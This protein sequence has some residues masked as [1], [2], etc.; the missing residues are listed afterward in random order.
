MVASASRSTTVSRTSSSSSIDFSANSFNSAE[1]R[2]TRKR[3]TA[4][5][6]AHLED[7]YRR[8]SHPTRDERDALA[9]RIQ[10]E[11]KSVTIWF[12]N[13]RQTDRKVALHNATNSRN[14]GTHEE[15]SS[16]TPNIT[17]TTPTSP[18]YPPNALIHQGA[19]SGSTNDRSLRKQSMTRSNT[20]RR[21][22]SHVSSNTSIS[23]TNSISRPRPSLDRVASRTEL[24]FSERPTRNVDDHIHH[25]N[26]NDCDNNFNTTH[27]N[28]NSALPPR[29]RTTTACSNGPASPPPSKDHPLWAT[30]LSSPITPSSPP[31]AELVAYTRT[32][33]TRTLEWA[34]ASARLAGEDAS[35]KFGLSMVKLASITFPAPVLGSP[36]YPPSHKDAAAREREY[37]E[38]TAMTEDEAELITPNGSQDMQLS[39]ENSNDNNAFAPLKPAVNLTSSMDS[40]GLIH[41]VHKPHN[42]NTMTVDKQGWEEDEMHAAL[43]LCG[44]RG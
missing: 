10:M 29:S 19:G 11:T 22:P 30:M 6:L 14:E 20:L 7:L 35:S 18:T 40:M 5:Q 25:T 26:G 15:T 3:I 41:S 16:D 13:K 32:R 8:S 39:W 27:L 34:C 2:R 4:A 37:E 1:Q 28:S 38:A 33:R 12:Q 17:L 9:K 43:A 21:A 23:C 42:T 31:P 44:L 36:Y 24:R